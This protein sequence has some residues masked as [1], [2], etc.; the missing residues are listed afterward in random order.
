MRSMT[1]GIACGLAIVAAFGLMAA[2]MATLS[3]GESSCVV[4]CLSS[5]CPLDPDAVGDQCKCPRRCP[6][7]LYACVTD[8]DCVVVD[9]Y[10]C[11][12]P[13]IT[14]PTAINKAFLADYGTWQANECADGK[15]KDT[16]QDSATCEAVCTGRCR[17]KLIPV[18]TNNGSCNVPYGPGTEYARCMQ[19]C[20]T[21]D[22]G[23]G[24]GGSAGDCAFPLADYC[25]SDCPTYDQSVEKVHGDCGNSPQYVYAA[26]GTCGAYRF[27]EQSSGYGGPT[28][29]FDGSGALVAVKVGTD[30]G[31][32]C[33]YT[34]DFQTFGPV[35]D[36]TKK[37]TE[38]FCAPPG[39]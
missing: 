18:C 20:A 7:G 25:A 23:G 33:N 22:G 28:L 24:D 1:P 12:E 16:S 19:D 39:M 38:K 31:S 21:V 11:A 5:L 8:A 26:C 9:E 29:Y 27:T 35:P 6:S 36:C 10:C 15:L 17:S 4:D 3:C 37:V 2:G 14:H 30:N 13:N 34:S 32:F